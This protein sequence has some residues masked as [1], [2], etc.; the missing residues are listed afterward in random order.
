MLQLNQLR[1][2]SLSTS[3]ALQVRLEGQLGLLYGL[4]AAVFSIHRECTSFTHAILIFG[5]A[6][7]KYHNSRTLSR[8]LPRTKVG[9]FTISKDL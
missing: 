5:K 7:G 2:E 6:R 9:R 3:L 1:R 8:K 4:R